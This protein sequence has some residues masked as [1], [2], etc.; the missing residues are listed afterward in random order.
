MIIPCLKSIIKH[1]KLCFFKIQ[2]ENKT[3]YFLNSIDVFVFISS[4]QTE[5]VSFP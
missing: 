1:E 2:S 3:Y 4:F 5:I